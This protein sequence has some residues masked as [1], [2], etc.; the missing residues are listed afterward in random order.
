[1]WMDTTPMVEVEAVTAARRHMLLVSVAPG[2]SALAEWPHQSAR[3][4]RTPLS[5]KPGAH[6]GVNEG[7]NGYYAYNNMDTPP[8]PPA[9]LARRAPPVR[10]AVSVPLGLPCPPA[11]TAP[12]LGARARGGKLPAAISLSV[13]GSR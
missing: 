3:H 10:R 4:S 1:M 13:H 6:R 5:A 11:A 2:S 12:T 9:P 7:V 8:A